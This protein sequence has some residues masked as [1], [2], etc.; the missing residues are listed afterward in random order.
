MSFHTQD[1]HLDSVYAHKLVVNITQMKS[2][3]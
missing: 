1:S 3:S 2:N